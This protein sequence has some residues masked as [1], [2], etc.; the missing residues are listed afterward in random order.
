MLSI[1]VDIVRTEKAIVLLVFSCE[2][3]D[4]KWIN[5]AH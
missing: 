2:W 5:E 1:L 4:Y 3:A